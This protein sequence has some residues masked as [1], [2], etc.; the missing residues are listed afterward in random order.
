MAEAQSAIEAAVG[1]VDF[2]DGVQEPDVGRFNPDDFPVI[3]FSVISDRP[4]PE[5]QEIVQSRI[6]PEISGLDGVMDV[7][8]AGTV[9]RSVRIT[10][11][12]GKLAANNIPLFQVA[13]ALSENNLTLP[14]GVIFDGSQ[15]VIAKT[16][17]TLESVEDIRGPHRRRLCN[18]RRR[19][20]RRCRHR[21]PR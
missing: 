19:A 10:V 15:A 8:L 4:L 7:S 11:D 13:G 6:V 21:H 1:G 14:A 12:A 17:H 2:P 18:H 16:T 3:Q 20:S 5:I 9:D